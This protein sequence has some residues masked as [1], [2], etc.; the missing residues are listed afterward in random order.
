MTKIL[1]WD[2]DGT[3][4]RN[5]KDKIDKHFESFKSITGGGLKL[6]INTSGMMDREIL[7]SLFE[8]NQML[9][10]EHLLISIYEQLNLRTRS[11]ISMVPSELSPN[12]LATLNKASHDGWVNGLLTGNT[13]TRAEIKL[14]NTG[15]W[16]Y[17]N[18]DFCFFGDKVSNRQELIEVAL[19]EI[20]PDMNS[21]I[22]LIGDTP[23]D[24]IAAKKTNLPI[25]SVATGNYRL[26]QLIE[27][28]PNLAI[29]DL[30]KGFNDLFRFINNNSC[31]LL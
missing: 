22:F 1:L 31:N 27:C 24:I 7:L 8:K 4:I 21:S 12:V 10:S 3:L 6:G 16:Q 13:S 19:D 14:E 23:L 26:N 29:E 30:L 15:I 28:S 11:H 25:V 17:L 9:F 18:L 20:K 2:I 5:S